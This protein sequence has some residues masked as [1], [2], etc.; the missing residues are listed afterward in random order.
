MIVVDTSK[1]SSR[2]GPFELKPDVCIYKERD[3]TSPVTDFSAMEMWIEFKANASFEPFEDPRGEGLSGE[4]L[5]EC[6]AQRP[7]E[8]DSSNGKY[9]RGQL[10]SY[11]LAQIGSQFRRFAFSVLI[12]RH[13]ARF[14]RWDRAGAVVSAQFDYKKDPHLLAEFFC[15]F[16]RLSPTERGHDESVRPSNLPKEAEL[17]IRDKLKLDAGTPLFAYDVP[18]DEKKMFTFYGPRPPCP[19][20]SLIGRSTRTLPVCEMSGT[21]KEIPRVYRAVYLK[22]TWRVDTKEMQPESDVYKK[23]EEAKVPNIAPFVCGGD[24]KGFGSKTD[25]NRL[26]GEERWG[27][28]WGDITAHALH[29]LVLGVIGRGLIFFKCTKELVQG[30]LDSMRGEVFRCHTTLS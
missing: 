14:I 22:D 24:L 20:Q 17:E 5:K 28:V 21:A 26:A 11:A 12:V 16:S 8:K 10:T 6:F 4:E 13:R 3:T 25:T 19:P 30:V 29:R 23:L 1:H 18:V 15:R 7:F 2:I 27:G 9:T